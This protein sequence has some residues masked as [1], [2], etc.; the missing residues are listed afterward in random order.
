MYKNLSP[1]YLSTTYLPVVV[2]LRTMLLADT[3][4]WYELWHIVFVDNRDPSTTTYYSY[5]TCT[6][7]SL[8]CGAHLLSLYIR[9][10]RISREWIIL[11]YSCMEFGYN[12]VPVP[13]WRNLE[14][15]REPERAETPIKTVSF[16]FK[17]SKGKTDGLLNSTWQQQQQTLLTTKYH[18]RQRPIPIWQSN[19]ST[20]ITP[21]VTAAQ[22]K[23]P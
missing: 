16:F 3:R 21:M 13:W 18:D 7:K 10:V 14:K 19:N 5:S 17:N 22:P 9:K 1:G 2:Q 11:M 20:A 6:L 12:F 23:T 15:E 8:F 4:W